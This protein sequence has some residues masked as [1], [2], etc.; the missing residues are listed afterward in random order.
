MNQQL[1]QGCNASLQ[2]SS[3]Q[4]AAIRSPADLMVELETEVAPAGTGTATLR[5]VFQLIY[6][7]IYY[8]DGG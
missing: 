1:R 5:G 4:T 3:A 7:N 6:W 8:G 2:S